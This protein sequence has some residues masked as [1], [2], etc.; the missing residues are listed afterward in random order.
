MPNSPSRWTASRWAACR[1]RWRH[2]APGRAR[3]STSKAASA[4]ASTP[5]RWTSNDAYGGTAATDRNLYVTSAAFDG[6][7]AAGTLTL[8]TSGTQSL[9]VTSSTSYAPGAAGGT[10]TTRGNDT[11]RVG[12]G[13]VTVYADGPSVNVV[14]GTGTLTF[15]GS[16]GADTVSAGSGTVK[17]SGGKD[18]LTF[19]AGTGKAT[20]TAGSGK[21]VYNIVN[22]QAGGTILIND[23]TAG[24]DSIHLSGYAGT[25]IK[26]ETVVNG[27]T[28]ITLTDHTA[29]TLAGATPNS[30]SIFS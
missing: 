25:G 2:T 14:G 7:K 5:S 26:S 1:P 17:L 13:A 28:Q 6:A 15:I 10:V 27:S 20:I 11:V 3:C 21:E 12:N 4:P 18:N 19:T 22:G 23:F 16:V 30:H 8:G 24:T 9:T 29:I